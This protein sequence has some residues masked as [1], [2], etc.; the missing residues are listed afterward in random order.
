MHSLQNLDQNIRKILEYVKDCLEQRIHECLQEYSCQRSTYIPAKVKSNHV[1][2]VDRHRD[3]FSFTITPYW[4]TLYSASLCSDLHHTKHLWSRWVYTMY[5]STWG[6]R[7]EREGK[8][9]QGKC[10]T[11]CLQ[12]GKQTQPAPPQLCK[13]MGLQRLQ[14]ELCVYPYQSTEDFFIVLKCSS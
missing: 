6:L 1:D 2:L 11:R 3:T 5:K 8:S 7:I 4:A 9:L 14:T 13:C 10:R 12:G